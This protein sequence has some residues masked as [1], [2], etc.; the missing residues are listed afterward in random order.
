MHSQSFKSLPVLLV[1][2]RREALA[3][4]FKA[5]TFVCLFLARRVQEASGRD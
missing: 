3:G 1:G 5:T 4:A 2:D